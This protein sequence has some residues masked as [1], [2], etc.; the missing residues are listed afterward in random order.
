MNDLKDYVGE[1][2]TPQ[3]LDR[4]KLVGHS[5]NVR[6]TTPGGLLTMDY[7]VGRITVTVDEDNKIVNI[8]QE[9]GSSNGGW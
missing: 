6:V 3:I 9:K 4:I 5:T 7:Q 2:C 1:Y 8:D